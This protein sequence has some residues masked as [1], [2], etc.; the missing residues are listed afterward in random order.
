[1][2]RDCGFRFSDKSNIESSVNRDRQLCAVLKEAKKLDSAIETKTVAGDRDK[3]GLL[4]QFAVHLINDGKSKHTQT[5][6]SGCL[7]RLNRYADLDNPESVK[8]YIATKKNDNTKSNYCV[9]YTSF[10]E[11]Q[12]KTWKAPKYRVSSPI[13]E[14]IPTEEELNQL[15]AGLGKKTATQV[16]MI[17]E[18]G[19][20]IGECLSLKWAS[21]NEKDNILTLNT[22]EK[23][24]LPRVFKVSSK[25]LM[26]I[27][28]LPKK[29]EKIFG[30][31]T[32]KDAQRCFAR[33]RKKIAQ[34]I[35][36]PRLAKIHFHLMRHW[37]GTMEYHKTHDF[38]HVRR[39]LGH[40]SILSTQIYVNMEKMLFSG[41]ANEYHVK[42]VSTVEEA[43]ALIKV[44][45]EY[46]TEIDN[47]KLFRKRK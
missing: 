16:Q 15:V 40:R 42:A 14:F 44:G 2:C 28:A 31:T 37:K 4:L 33:S 27:Q 35:G 17:M 45:F 47:K 32:A 1:L 12:G 18:T 41:N 11:W 23:H 30:V 24:S 6:Y 20:R 10:L 39:L 7:N 5:T 3:R 9:A 29:N 36:N 13:P 8:A 26:M 43:T 21:L 22:P 38:D 25:L 46:V 34:K 19:M